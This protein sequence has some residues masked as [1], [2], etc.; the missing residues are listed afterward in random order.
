MSGNDE[1]VNHISPKCNT[2]GDISNKINQLER[3]TDQ[4]KVSVNGLYSI[5]NPDLIQTYY[6]NTINLL[7][8]LLR[9]EHISQ[10]SLDI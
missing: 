10:R 9:I 2:P 3:S 8:R 1:M 7:Q 5:H 4:L 6:G